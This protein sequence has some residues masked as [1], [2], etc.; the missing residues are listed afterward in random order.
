MSYKLLGISSFSL[1]LGLLASP[2]ANAENSAP[3]NDKKTVVISVHEGKVTSEVFVSQAGSSAKDTEQAQGKGNVFV[4]HDRYGRVL[5]IRHANGASHTFSQSEGSNLVTLTTD[6]GKKYVIKKISRTNARAHL[7]G[8]KEAAKHIPAEQLNPNDVQRASMVMEDGGGSCD[9]EGDCVVI[10]DGGGGG[11]DGGGGG[12]GGS[13]GGGGV[14]IIGDG[15]GGYG[16]GGTE[17]SLPPGTAPRDPKAIHDCMNN[18]YIAWEKMD[19]ICKSE[20]NYRDRLVCE[21]VNMRLYNEER[22]FCEGR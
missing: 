16:S 3:K 18:A 8:N 6:S 11:G 10:I 4:E 1:V 17:P 15:S 2:M 12:G 22:D 14:I 7:F 20:R 5:S 19:A 13:D 9:E 21:E